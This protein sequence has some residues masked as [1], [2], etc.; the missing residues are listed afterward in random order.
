MVKK[1]DKL[2]RTTHEK[3]RVPPLPVV[4]TLLDE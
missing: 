2:L 3:N 4:V 1:L